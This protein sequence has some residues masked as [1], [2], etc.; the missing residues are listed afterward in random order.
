MLALLGLIPGLLGV[1]ERWQKNKY[2]AEVAITT[3][4][5]GGDR[6]VAVA[7]IKG[8]SSRFAAV[9]GSKLLTILVVA[10]AAPLVIYINKV[11]VWDIVLGLGT[12]DPIKG[13]VADWANTIIAFIFG[14]PTALALGK[15]FFSRG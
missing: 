13:Q 3:A 7:Q 14:A 10:F 5:I 15:M 6:D 8:Q 4:K 2:D 9:A 12:T 1:I 11:V